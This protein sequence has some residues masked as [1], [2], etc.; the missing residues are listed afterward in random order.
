MIISKLMLTIEQ[1][2]RENN[3]DWLDVSI[4]PYGE[5]GKIVKSHLDTLQRINVVGVYDN[6]IHNTGAIPLKMFNEQKSTG[7]VLL[8]AASY[9]KTYELLLLA[10]KVISQDKIL[11]PFA[12]VPI[13]KYSN[14]PLCGD[15]CLG[16]VESIGAF[17]SF[18]YG[19]IVVGQHEQHISTHELFSYPG[20]WQDHPGYMYGTKVLKHRNIN[21]TVIG[22][23]V[24]IGR[25]VVIMPGIKIGNGAIVG[26]NAV[27]TKDIPDYAVA[28][29]VPARVVRY[30]YNPE[31][32]EWLNK[33]K[34]WNWKDEKII[35]YQED[36]Y[37]DIEEFI[38]KHKGDVDENCSIITN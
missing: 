17:C 15:V 10:R 37:L 1:Y 13:G 38:E 34:W 14:G 19:A 23:D 29:G 24:W 9:E 7:G 6:N 31:Q 3:C 32:I 2:M 21:K 18:A 16:S 36:F 4:F 25:N 28:V 33:I 35:K 11:T 8:I 26:A 30:R 12:L 5:Y 27:V 20:N 22:N